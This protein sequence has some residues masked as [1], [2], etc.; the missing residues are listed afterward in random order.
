MATRN[1]KNSALLRLFKRGDASRLH[2]AHVDRVRSILAALDGPNP[3]RSLSK[4]TYRLHPLTGDRQGQ[5][6]VTVSR[7]WRIVFR[8][9]GAAVHDV[10]LTDYH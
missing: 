3:L 4:P 7:N 2:P 6:A 5:W 9:D 8:C 10:D 1:I